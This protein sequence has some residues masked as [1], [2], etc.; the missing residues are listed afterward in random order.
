MRYQLGQ[1]VI[2]NRDYP[3]TEMGTPGIV[4][5]YW[6]DIS[7]FKV[8]AKFPTGLEIIQWRDDSV[9]WP[10]EMH[11]MRYAKPSAQLNAA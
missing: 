9:F 2:L 3:M 8:M 11:A 4:V 7:G 6:I 5:D 1:K 10:E